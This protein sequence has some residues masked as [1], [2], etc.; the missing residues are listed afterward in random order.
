MQNNKDSSRFRFFRTFLIVVVIVVVY[1]YGFQVT[2]INLE[3]P[4][5]PRRQQQ[6]TN[7]IRALARPDLFVF[8][9]DRIEINRA[10]YVPCPAGS[11][12]LPDLSQAGE[13]AVALSSDCAEPGSEIT[14]TGSGFE[15]GDTALIF[16]VPY[17]EDVSQE[18]Q[19]P[20]SNRPLAVDRQGNFETTVTVRKDRTSENPQQVRVVVNRAEGLPAPSEAVYD[21][22]EKIIET[23]FLALIATTL[24]TA[25]SIPVSFLAARNLM[26]QVTTLFGS[27]V[28]LAV[29]APLGWYLGAWLYGA[30]GGWGANLIVGNQTAAAA[31]LLLM[32]A[33]LLSTA[34]A[35]ASRDGGMQGVN[36]IKNYGLGILT[37]L[38]VALVLGLVAGVGQSAGLVL[39]SVL[40]PFGF[41]GHFLFVISDSL[42]VF[43]PVIGGLA[44]AFAFV[45]LAGAYSENLLRRI[46]GSISGKIYT[47]VMS[48]L[49]GIVLAGLPA[50]LI[51]WLY[52]LTNPWFSIWLPAIIGGV[53]M[54]VIG[55]VVAADRAM[56][57]GMIV[58][59]TTRTVLN[60]LRAIEPLIMAIVFVVWVGIGP[61][62]GVLA[63]TLHTIAALGKLYSE[64]VE[65]ISQGPIEAVTATGANRL[66]TVIYAVI[67]QI[68]PP[69]IAFTIYRWDIN[70]RMSTIIGFAGGGGIGFLLQQNLNL[71]KYRQAAV[72]MIAIAIVVAS[73]DYISAKIRERII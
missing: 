2:D 9:T 24:G 11:Y 59:Y 18:V 20:L 52:E 23:V 69:Y 49:A 28:T 41:L 37:A 62:A 29:V 47:V 56:A 10:I 66:Q 27:L 57:T 26:I 6:L 25:L 60:V 38:A 40:G 30:I 33:V 13:P 21:T 42:V 46:G 72:Q 67:P 63:L 16:F 14:I 5:E 22:V 44:G 4:K 15:A 39:K 8:E 50:M 36:T 64:Q 7:V 73:L 71:L 19:L 35:L 31:A 68:V 17:K 12:T 1:A 48:V 43:L 61:F 45:S 70:V 54:G 3:E 51:T 32:P 55:L 65:N 34:Q 53:V 58:Y